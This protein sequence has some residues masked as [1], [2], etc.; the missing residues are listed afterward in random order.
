[1]DEQKQELLRLRDSIQ[2]KDHTISN[3]SRTYNHELLQI[4]RET[5]QAAENHQNE[6]F[7]VKQKCKRL[8]HELLLV[9]EE[10]RATHTECKNVNKSLKHTEMKANQ[11]EQDKEMVTFTFSFQYKL[12]RDCATS[13]VNTL[14]N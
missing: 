13:I 1:M 11:Y 5:N 6:T 9:K 2:K 14:C 8:E 7:H 10:L 4:K 3:H 12:H